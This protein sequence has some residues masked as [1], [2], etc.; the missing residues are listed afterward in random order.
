MKQRKTEKSSYMGNHHH[1][2]HSK[3][4]F[5]YNLF[6]CGFPNHP[7]FRKWI[8][9]FLNF[10][11]GCSKFHVWTYIWFLCVSSFQFSWKV[12]SQSSKVSI[13]SQITF[14][15]LRFYEFWRYS[16]KASPT[17]SFFFNSRYRKRSGWHWLCCELLG[18]LYSM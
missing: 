14:L 5:Q 1:L 7:C 6:L 13:R 12:S 15:T 3:Y 16:I 18:V 8:V 11:L 17:S 2:F 9:R 4:F 10:F